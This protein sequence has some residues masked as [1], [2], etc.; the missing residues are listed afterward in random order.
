MNVFVIAE[1]HFNHAKLV[2]Y[3]NRPEDFDDII[4]ANWNAL[5]RPEDVVFH[6]GDVALGCAFDVA[7]MMAR[8]AGRKLLCLGNHDR[9]DPLCY[10]ARFRLRLPLRR[11]PRRRLQP[12]A[13]SSSSRRTAPSTSTAIFTAASTGRASTPP[14]TSTNAIA[15]ATGSCRSRTPSSPSRSRPSCRRRPIARDNVARPGGRGGAA[16]G[17]AFPPTLR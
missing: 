6:P 12:P 2:E 9:T 4:V 13:P 16:A 11:L 5:V 3:E 8:L 14:T 17:S 7:G 15:T 10:M 1:T